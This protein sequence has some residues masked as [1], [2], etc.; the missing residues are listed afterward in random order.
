MSSYY[1]LLFIFILL[2]INNAG[3]NSE[4]KRSL[5]EGNKQ[6]T[7]HWYAYSVFLF[8]F[9]FLS[10]LYWIVGYC[11]LPLIERIKKKKEKEWKATIPMLSP[12]VFLNDS[13]PTFSFKLLKSISLMGPNLVLTCLEQLK[14]AGSVA[15]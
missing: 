5:Q 1:V 13:H 14:S 7:F 10:C 8:L 4:K 2:H 15:P 12:N 6:L 3:T 9:L 11:Y